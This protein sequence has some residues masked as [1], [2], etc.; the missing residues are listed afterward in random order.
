MATETETE[1]KKDSTDSEQE[2]LQEL[3]KLYTKKI[4]KMEEVQ[5][6]NTEEEP[7]VVIYGGV[8]DM[9]DF[10]L[11]HPGGPDVL[12]DIAGQGM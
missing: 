11:D 12:Q 6:H 4:F 1:T 10:Q 9:T 7:W 8:Y 5:K 2:E 3:K